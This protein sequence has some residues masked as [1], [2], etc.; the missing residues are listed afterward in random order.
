MVIFYHL[1]IPNC[2]HTLAP[3]DDLANAS[4]TRNAPLAWC[5]VFLS[6]FNDIKS[7]LADA[8]LLVH[9]D[10][11]API[12]IAL[13]AVL[14][15]YLNGQWCPLTFFSSSRLRPN[16]TTAHLAATLLA[17]YSAVK[18]FLYFLEGRVFTV[19]TDHK[20]LCYSLTSSTS[21]HSPREIRHLAFISEFTTDIGHISGAN[22]P[23]ADAPLSRRGSVLANARPRLGQARRRSACRHRVAVTLPVYLP[24][25]PCSGP[26]FR[27]PVNLDL[28]CAICQPAHRDRTC[29][30]HAVALPLT[31]ST[32]LRTQEFVQHASWSL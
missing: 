10:T 3:I 25:A 20:L 9:P 12:S 19:S 17:I 24:Q 13:D 7:S 16:V 31:R 23:V 26:M 15:Q 32:S 1:F 8:T 2:A 6:A 27:C 30:L 5:D 11:N 21:R 18:H 28:F 29:N 22:N 4:R 14:Q